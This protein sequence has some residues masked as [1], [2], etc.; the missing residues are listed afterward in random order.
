MAKMNCEKYAE[1]ALSGKEINEKAFG[2]LYSCIRSY[3]FTFLNNMGNFTEVDKEDIYSISFEKLLKNK[4]SGKDNWKKEKGKFK[5]YFRG[6][7]RN[8]ALDF[9]SKKKLIP[10]TVEFESEISDKKGG[11]SDYDSKLNHFNPLSVAVNNSIYFTKIEFSKKQPN[12][13]SAIYSTEPNHNANPILRHAIIT[14]NISIETVQKIV[15]DFKNDSTIFDSL[16]LLKTR[17]NSWHSA[18]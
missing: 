18:K 5:Y 3:M 10:N 15:S 9:L 16:N 13:E 17:Y 4:V 12:I 2:E 6:I 11:E 8:A 14:N 1:L 7:V